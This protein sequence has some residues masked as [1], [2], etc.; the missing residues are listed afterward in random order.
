MKSLLQKIILKNDID[1]LKLF[2]DLTEKDKSDF[3]LYFLDFCTLNCKFENHTDKDNKLVIRILK[4]NCIYNINYN[5]FHIIKN[6]DNYIYI[7][8]NFIKNNK[9]NDL[10]SLQFLETIKEIKL[11]KFIFLEIIENKN[12]NSFE[13]EDINFS[14]ELPLEDILMNNL[15]IHIE[16]LNEKERNNVLQFVIH[17]DI[18]LNKENKFWFLKNIGFY[19]RMLKANLHSDEE[20]LNFFVKYIEKVDKNLQNKYIYDSLFLGGL[21]NAKEINFNFIKKFAIEKPLLY[22]YFKYSFED[23]IAFFEDVNEYLKI[24]DLIDTQ[25]QMDNF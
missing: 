22:N 11:D 19:E 7:V 5:I 2:N 25:I 23:Y 10:L 4:E 15:Y 21:I 20:E 3:I 13:Y 12:L 6:F 8:N 14:Y 1:K 18:M 9:V 24:F 17:Y 16:E